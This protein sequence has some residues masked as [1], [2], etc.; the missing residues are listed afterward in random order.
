MTIDRI[1]RLLA[2]YNIVA[3]TA[4]TED[5]GKKVTWRY[6]PAPVCKWLT[7]N[8]EGVE[9][10]AGDMLKKL[11]TDDAILI[12][13]TLHNCSNKHCVTILNNCYKALPDYGKVIIVERIL[14]VNPTVTPESQGVF[15]V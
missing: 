8:D 9:Q 14:Q 4:E 10:V 5:N 3:C 7:K 13:Y 12:K 2:S 1:L 15:D 6:G 11:P